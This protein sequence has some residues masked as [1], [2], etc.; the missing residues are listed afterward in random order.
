[1]LDA[2]VEAVVRH[3]YAGAT[4]KRIAEIAGIGEATLF[5]RFGTKEGLL[6]AALRAEAATFTSET[7]GYT[8]DLR[9][10]LARVVGA[11]QRVMEHRGRLA[12]NVLAELPRRPELRE[13]MEAPSAAMGGVALLLQRYQTEGQLRGETPWEVLLPLLSPVLLAGALNQLHPTVVG[14]FDAGAHVE[15]FLSG[16]ES[17]D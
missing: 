7:A 1:M 14:S 15:R 2:A 10:D 5:R 3:G 8:G 17:R 6:Q 4:T 16:W 9:A 12:L 13:V 11:Y